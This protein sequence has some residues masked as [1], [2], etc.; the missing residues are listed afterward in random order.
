MVLVV[1]A[2]GAEIWLLLQLLEH[3]VQV[4]LTC[5]HGMLCGSSLY[6][7]RVVLLCCCCRLPPHHYHHHRRR[8]FLVKGLESTLNK[9]ILSLEFYDDA[10]RKK[11]AT[12]ELHTREGGIR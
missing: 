4:L 7:Q 5:N 9:F 8:P 3:T 2:A 11:I 6:V 10:G 12:S 1:T